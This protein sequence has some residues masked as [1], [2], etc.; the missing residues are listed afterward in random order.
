MEDSEENKMLLEN[1]NPQSLRY[2]IL[3]KIFVLTVSPPWLT[4]AKNFVKVSQ[5][6]EIPNFAQAVSLDL[7]KKF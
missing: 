1:L 5:F 6:S 7:M 3:M 2:D 4:L